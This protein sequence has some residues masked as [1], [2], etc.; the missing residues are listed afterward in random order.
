MNSIFRA[1]SSYASYWL[2]S[3]NSLAFPFST[4]LFRSFSCHTSY[5]LTPQLTWHFS[6]IVGP[7]QG[8][9]LL[10]FLLACTLTCHTPGPHTLPVFM[11]TFCS[12][13]PSTVKI[14]AAWPCE[15][16]VSN[17]HI[18]WH[19][20][21]EDHEFCLHCC[22]NLEYHQQIYILHDVVLLS[23]ICQKCNAK[24]SE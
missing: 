15:V 24:N 19:N 8:T 20:N 1:F 10:H 23:I 21:P 11:S 4:A 5:Y 7:V 9:F 14:E 18:T 13:C 2:L 3:A 16:L 17:Y 6:F 22:E 12:P